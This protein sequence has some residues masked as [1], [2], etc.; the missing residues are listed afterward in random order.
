MFLLS[1]HCFP[2][3]HGHSS[4]PDCL[5]LGFMGP[6]IAEQ[7]HFL[8]FLCLPDTQAGNGRA[9]DKK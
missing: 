6:Q 1:S 5:S 2:E 8:F 3:L 4:R 7:D 9:F